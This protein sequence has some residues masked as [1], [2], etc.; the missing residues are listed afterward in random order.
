MLTIR[1]NRTGKKNKAYFRVVL[2]E[3]TVAPGGRHVE[4][5]GSWDPHMKK[6]VLKADRIQY[7]ISKGAQASDTAYNL[8]IKEGVIQGKKRVVKLPEKKEAEVEKTA[9]VKE[10]KE[11]EVKKEEAKPA[12]EKVA[13]VKKEESKAEEVVVDKK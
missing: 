13:E 2:Q 12:E 6:A 11:E 9:E 8:F 7:W 10:V 4:I 1:F 3:H 5:L